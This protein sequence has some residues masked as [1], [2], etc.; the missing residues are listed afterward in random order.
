MLPACP[1]SDP[2]WELTPPASGH[3]RVST[4]R[5]P[6]KSSWTK[7]PKRWWIRN[8]KSWDLSD[9]A[10][11]VGDYFINHRGTLDLETLAAGLVVMLAPG[12]VITLVLWTG[13]LA[14]FRR[15]GVGGTLASL[16]AREPDRG[17]LKELQLADAVE[18]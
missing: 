1:T 11:R 13:V 7:R 15:G 3:R 12:I 16:N 10:L 4:A 2:R 5:G 6:M 18:E 9:L 14:L 8:G 17:D